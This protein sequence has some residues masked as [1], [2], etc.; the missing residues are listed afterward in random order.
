MRSGKPITRTEAG[1]AGDTLPLAATV[2]IGE[3]VPGG[4]K[5][6]ERRPDDTGRV[7]SLAGMIARSAARG[8]AITRRLPSPRRPRRLSPACARS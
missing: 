4:A 5:L 1:S 3:T 2:A 7:R 6:I 8:V